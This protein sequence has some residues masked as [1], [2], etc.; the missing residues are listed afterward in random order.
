MLARDTCAVPPPCFR[1]SL[2]LTRSS[3]PSFP[4]SP[5]FTFFPADPFFSPAAFRFGA[6]LPSNNELSLRLFSKIHPRLLITK[7]CFQC[8]STRGQTAEE[9]HSMLFMP[10]FWFRSTCSMVRTQFGSWCCRTISSTLAFSSSSSSST[11]PSCTQPHVLSAV[12]SP[13]PK[14]NTRMTELKGLRR[15]PVEPPLQ[16]ERGTQCWVR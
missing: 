12:L 14:T 10:E 3:A 7:S 11:I 13:H 2:A 1:A 5:F 4:E 6:I 8:A 9:L 16:G 15:A